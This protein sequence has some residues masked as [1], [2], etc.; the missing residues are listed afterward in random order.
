MWLKKYSDE[1]ITSFFACRLTNSPKGCPKFK[2]IH[3]RHKIKGFT[4]IL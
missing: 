1:Y 3:V 2:D 4:L